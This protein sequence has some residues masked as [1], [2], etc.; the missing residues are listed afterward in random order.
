MNKQS[1]RISVITIL[2]LAGTLA[3]IA[4]FALS[5]E[6]IQSV[7]SRFMS[8]L[9][10]HDVDTLTDLSYAGNQT[11]E[12]IRK[13]WDYAVNV[14]G[15][16]Y[17]FTWRATSSKEANADNGAVQLSVSRNANQPG[18]YEENF[19]LPMVK[20][21]NDWKVDVTGISRDMFPGL[22]R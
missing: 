12:E 19:Q 1:G 18:S 17:Y 7:G 11:K 4:I 10:R 15:Q 16:H 3:I 6:S 22:P 5:R 20:V 9:S 2:V 21:N 14:A 13:K 8:A